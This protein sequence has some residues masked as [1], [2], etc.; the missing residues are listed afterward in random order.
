MSENNEISNLRAK[1]EKALAENE[2]R[3]SFDADDVVKIKRL[4][5]AL[6]L[7]DALGFFSKYAFY[8]LLAA[9]AILANLDRI[10]EWWK[11][12]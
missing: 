5:R 6:D 12:L 2:N 8:S 3:H 9:G 11:S 4:M 1:L 10:V 7:F